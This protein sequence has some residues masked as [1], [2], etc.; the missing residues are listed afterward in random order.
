[1]ALT[2]QLVLLE[3]KLQLALDFLA[4]DAVN[5]L[6]ATNAEL[7][8]SEQRVFFEALLAGSGCLLE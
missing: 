8:G 1:M 7:P 6:A 2:R 5:S 4:D 3:L